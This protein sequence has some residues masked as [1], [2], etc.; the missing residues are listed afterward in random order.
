MSPYSPVN[1]YQFLYK[2]NKNKTEITNSLINYIDNFASKNNILSCN[3]LY[4]NEDWGELLRSLGYK[5]W[6]NTSSES[7]SYT[8]LTLPTKRIV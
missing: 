7:V 6:I 3:F 2:E 4:V 1:G 5:E 8:H